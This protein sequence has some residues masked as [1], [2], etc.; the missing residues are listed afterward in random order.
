MTERLNLTVSG[1]VQIVGYRK[2]VKKAAI[3]FNVLGHVMNQKDG[4][5][6]IVC[7]GT[8]ENLRMFYDAIFIRKD[9]IYVDKIKKR[10]GKATGEFH[11][12]WVQDDVVTP[13][14]RQIMERLDK[15]LD[16]TLG[17]RQDI[18][19]GRVET[20]EAIET[21][22]SHLETMDSHL[23]T[24]DSHLETMDSHVQGLD[25][26]QS[27]TTIAVRAMDVHMSSR[28]DSLDDKY[29]EFGG[30]MKCM[31][32]DMKDMKGSMSDISLDIHAIKL[33]AFPPKRRGKKQVLK[34]ARSRS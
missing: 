6:K 28:F 26:N 5:V 16:L 34:Q 32:S 19:R 31:A 1:N 25:K 8:K 17:I 20:V 29:G 11:Q 22:D 14:E 30:T 18:S 12:F 23:E 2:E 15:G 7:E 27:G 10:S 24:M 13:G 21:M 3:Q 9:D 33:A 4:T